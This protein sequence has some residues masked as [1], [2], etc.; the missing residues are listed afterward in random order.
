MHRASECSLQNVLALLKDAYCYA[1]EAKA[2]SWDFAV[3]MEEL[4]SSGASVSDLRWL[5]AKRLIEHGIERTEH[6]DCLRQFTCKSSLRFT[7]RSCFV[8]TELGYE[9]REQNIAREII[10]LGLSGPIASSQADLDPNRSNDRERPDWD[11]ERRELRLEGKLVKKFRWAAPNQELVLATFQEDDW[12]V[13]IDDPLPPVGD[14][15]PKRRLHDTI[16]ALNRNQFHS[17]IK[18]RGDGTG[19]GIVWELHDML[20]DSLSVDSREISHRP[21]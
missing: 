8:L 7:E 17:A 12:P 1:L 2:S 19:Q 3:E 20:A 4:R 5:I 16:K 11:G 21:R 18:F 9:L 15:D 6:G 10:P 14:Q 13:R